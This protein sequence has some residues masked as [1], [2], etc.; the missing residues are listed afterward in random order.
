MNKILVLAG[1]TAVGKTEYSIRLAKALDGEIISADS[2][3]IYEGMDIGSAKPSA[4][5]LAMVPHHLIGE[6]D[7]RRA[8]SAA[9]YQIL[10]RQYIREVQKRGK[11]PIIAGG[12]GLYVNSLLYDMDFSVLPRQEGFREQLEEEA[13]R[14][15]PEVLHR[16][17]EAL[18]P[19]AAAR[20]HPNNI[21]KVIRAIEVCQASGESF[22]EFEASFKKTKEYDVILIGLERERQEL[23]GRIERRVDALMEQGLEQEVSHLLEKGLQISDISMKGIG[24][25]EIISYLQGEYDRE[26]AIR[27][28]K[29]NTRRYA[30]RQMTWFRRYPDMKWFLLTEE[31]DVNAKTEELLHEVRALLKGVPAE[32]DGNGRP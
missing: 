24:Y 15:G 2:M 13:K 14:E 26:E 10:A 5:E 27:L 8:F 30:K 21:K 11:L 16:R 31:D 1:P 29:Q 20:I 9:E 4:A 7:P 3:Q 17:L 6:I 23:Y 28:I 22:P 32:G 18:D 25:K 19:E 12:T